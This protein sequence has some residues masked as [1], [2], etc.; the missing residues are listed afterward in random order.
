MNIAGIYDLKQKNR[1]NKN[2]KKILKYFKNIIFVETYFQIKNIK[3][4]E[5]KKVLAW[6]KNIS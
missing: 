3:L 2:L 6:I 1:K 4:S 5:T